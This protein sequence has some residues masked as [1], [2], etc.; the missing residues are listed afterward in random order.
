MESGSQDSAFLR[1][2]GA[3]PSTAPARACDTLR[4]RT[5]QPGDGSSASP[6]SSYYLGTDAPED[7]RETARSCGLGYCTD[8]LVSQSDDTRKKT[9]FLAVYYAE[10][11]L[12][13]AI[14]KIHLQKNNIRTSEG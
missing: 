4:P 5:A 9:L 7:G 8:S 12:F 10:M 14:T 1:T 11:T 2:A 3:L 13:T 6:H